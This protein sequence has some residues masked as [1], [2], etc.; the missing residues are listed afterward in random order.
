MQIIQLYW[1]FDIPIYICGSIYSNDFIY[2]YVL[3][4]E[5]VLSVNLCFAA[6]KIAGTA[7]SGSNRSRLEMIRGFVRNALSS[8]RYGAVVRWQ[9]GLCWRRALFVTRLVA[10]TERLRPYLLWPFSVYAYCST[11]T[12]TYAGAYKFVKGLRGNMY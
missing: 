6:N 10:E 3:A 8:C 2:A 12:T 7:L 1:D 5:L 4:I 9:R 11:G